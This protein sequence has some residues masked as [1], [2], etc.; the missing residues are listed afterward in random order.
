MIKEMLCF[1]KV[2]VLD[3]VDDLNQLESLAGDHN[4]LGSRSRIIV[5]TKDKHLLEVH[6][7]DALFETRKLD[8]KEAIELVS[9]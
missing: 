6:E 2:L 9:V 8:H 7:M 1:K 5:T 4:W 3:N